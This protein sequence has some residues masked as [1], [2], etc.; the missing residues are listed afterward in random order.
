MIN[1]EQQVSVKKNK[2]KIHENNI[3]KLYCLDDGNVWF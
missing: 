1:S 3:G 2:Y